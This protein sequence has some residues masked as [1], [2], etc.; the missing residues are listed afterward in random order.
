MF[1]CIPAYHVLVWIGKPIMYAAIP[2]VSATLSSLS[3]AGFVACLVSWRQGPIST[4]CRP[5]ALEKLWIILTVCWSLGTI[6]TGHWR[7][8]GL[9]DNYLIPFPADEQ[10]TYE[11]NAWRRQRGIDLPSYSTSEREAP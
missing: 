11:I 1:L 10:L 3:F 6:A 7:K 8:V 4:L 5:A 9:V 2:I